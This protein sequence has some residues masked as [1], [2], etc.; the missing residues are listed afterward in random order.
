MGRGGGGRWTKEEEEELKAAKRGYREAVAEGNREEEARWA[1]VIGD[2]H[3]RRGEYVEAL[4][5]LRIDYKVSVKYLPQRHLLPSCQS[6]GEVHLRLGN[7]SEALTY[8]KKHLQLAKEAD[9]L[10]EQQRASTQLGRTYYEILLRSENDHSAIRNAKKYFKSSM[11][12]ARVLKENPSSQKS[13]FL[14][15]LIDAYNNMGML[16]LELDNYE[17]AE[18]LLVQ[19]L[20]IC[21]EEEVHQYD[22]ARS[23]LHHNLGNVYIELR[24]W[25]RAKG[26]IEKDIE[27]CRKI[28]HTQGE[29]KGFINLGEV[30][31]RVQKYEDAKLCYNKALQITKCLEDEDALMDQIHQNIETVT[32]AAKVLEEMKTDEQK[33]KKLV[34]DTSNA[35]GTSKERKLLLE[36]YAWLDNLM[37]KARMITAW[38]KLKEFSKGQKRVANELH[39]KE[40][41]SN[42]LLVI[43]ESY[44][45]L[46]NFSKARKWCMKS[47]NMYRSIGNLEGQALAK[48]NI[49]NVLDSCGDWAGALQAYEEAYRISVEG[50]LS[51]VQ[52]DAL[53]NM[54]YSHMVRFDNIEEA[55]K[56]QQ[57]IDSLK[58]MSDQHEARDTVSDYCSETESEDGNVSDNILNTEDNDGNIANNISEEFDDDVV[59]ASLVHKSKSSKTKA[60]KIHSSPKNVDESCDMD[61]S[62][63]EVVSKSFSNHSGRKRVRV[64]ISDD[65]AE[66]APEIDQSKRTLTGRA[67]S[68]STS[69]RI[70]NAANRNRNQHTSHPIETKEVDSVCTPCPAEES[71]CSFKSGSPVCHGNDGPDL[72]ASS[73]GKLSVSKPAASGSKVGTHASNSRPQCQNAVGLQ[74][75]DADHKFWVFKIGEL[76]VYL[77]ANACTCEGAFSIECL[78]VEVACVYYL[79]IPDEKRSKGLLPIIGELKCCGKVLDDTDSRDYIDQLA[80]EQKCIDVVIDDWVPKRLMKLYVDFCTKLS[81]APNK[82]LLKKLYNLEVSEDE[83]IVSDCGLQDLSIT[84][85][86]DAL[87]LHK[88]IAVLD[89]SHNMLGNQTIERLQQI[90]SSSSQTYGGLTLDLHCNRFGPTALF[91]ICEC[92]VMTNRLEVLNLS[93]NR[94]TDACGSYLFTILQKCKALYS[95]NV[96]QCSITSRTVQKMAD[97]LHEGSALSHL[98]L[99]NNNP[100]SGNTM[101]SLLSKLASLKRFSELSLTGIKLSKLMVDKLCVLAQSSCLSGFLL[102]GTYIGSGGATKLT[103]ALSCASQELLRLDLSNCGLTTPDFSQLCTNLSQI[104]I[105]D[106][107]LGGNSFTLEECDA[108]RALLSNPQCSLRSLTLDRCNLGLAGT[109]GIIQALAG[110]DQLEELR[111]AENTNLALQR[112]LQ[113]DEDAQDVSPGTDQNQRTNAEANDHI[114]PDKM[115]VP[116][117]EDE[118]AVHEDTRAATGPDGSCASSCQRNSSSGC[119]AIQELADAIISAKQLKV[120]DLSRNGLSEEDI[121]SLYSAWASGPRGDGMARK[122]VAKEVVHF[123]V[124]GMNCCGLKPCCRRD[125]QM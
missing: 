87:R 20:K 45:K 113:Y 36:Q 68:L 86:L 91:Q 7:F 59:L 16:E 79:Q 116:D 115:E 25:N 44:Q 121:Q 106:L 19:G 42:S 74:S 75:S 88:T 64:V 120:L 89:L 103:E 3:K 38:P 56:L 78:K 21:E 30:H 71:I 53:E 81:E 54:H 124:D 76:L 14:K 5:W 70:A 105:V 84:P 111:V 32:K 50:G 94:L 22:D 26:H 39:D 108:I 1:N 41:Q 119:H 96:E 6:L 117:S 72:G 43:G 101:L 109:V 34:R 15:E 13:L 69:E 114:D 33:L 46:R 97:A 122:H 48:V 51:N 27:I 12:L 40:K 93:G 104:N 17:E 98:S 8:Q 92:A 65:E 24:N 95:L 31:S 123:A 85:F 125:L 29:A 2:I 83:V 99:G 4:R 102:G 67:D 77:D 23:R 112:T 90:F 63:E 35:R 61:G 107:N 37:E 62:P 80:S 58:R 57:E 73:I 60:S 10:V 28:R 49:G 9:D 11:K 52:L 47:W 100:I 55:K 118:E 110:N 66:E 82:K 18:K